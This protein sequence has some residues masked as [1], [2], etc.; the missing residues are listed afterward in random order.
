MIVTQLVTQLST[1]DRVAVSVPTLLAQR[2][3]GN[4]NRRQHIGQISARDTPISFLAVRAC[5]WQ[6]GPVSPRGPGSSRRILATR[7]GR[8]MSVI[9]AQPVHE[10][11]VFL[12][13][14]PPIEEYVS[15]VIQ[16]SPGENVDLPALAEQ[17]RDSAAV[18]D[19]LISS[20]PGAADNRSAAPLPDSLDE[21]AAQFMGDP[22]VR[23]AYAFLP[24]RIAMISLDDLVVFQ[25]QINLRV[26]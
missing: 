8:Q 18:V 14:R 26:R 1:V 25:K 12:L 22:A 6:S 20:E 16:A 13:G 9:A 17:W 5:I 4:V 21:A 11:W 15:F 19:G 2:N 23:A 7:K 3:Q 10:P 24:A